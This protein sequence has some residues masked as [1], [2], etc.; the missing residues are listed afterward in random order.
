[1]HELSLCKAIAETAT[2]HAAGRPIEAVN[3]RIGHLRQVVPQTLEY[4]WTIATQETALAGSD[5]FVDYVPAAVTC[6]ECQS[7]TTL[8]D[9]VLRCGSC[10]SSLVDM[11][12]G[13]EFMI[14]S[15]DVGP[16]VTQPLMSTEAS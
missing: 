15:I 10:D 9:P 16:D 6:R 11:V 4:C 13:D 12:S 3:L 1:M 8:E 2:Q 14:E 5:L 7:L